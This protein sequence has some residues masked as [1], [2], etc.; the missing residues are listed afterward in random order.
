MTEST[1][2][3]IESDA[4]IMMG[5]PVITGTRITVESILDRIAAGESLSEI[6]K[7]HPKI[8]IEH[9]KATL[10]YATEEIKITALVKWYEEG[11]IS[12]SKASEIAGMSRVQFLNCLAA[13]EVSPFQQ[14]AA[15]LAADVEAALKFAQ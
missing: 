12:Q 9:I 14:S 7:S 11:V 3:Y 4:N 2:K 5:K 13:H 1:A 15:E 8:N 6:K 10:Q